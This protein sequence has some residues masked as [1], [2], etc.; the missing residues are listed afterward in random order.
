M[1]NRRVDI[2]PAVLLSAYARGIFPMADQADSPEIYWV[3]PLWRGV[4]PLDGFRVSRSLKKTMRK[5]GY[6]ITAD[7]AFEDV[8]EGCADREETWINKKIRSLYIDLFKLGHAHS[9]EVWHDGALV[10]GLYGVSLGAAFFGESMFNRRPNTSKIALAH[11]V[12]RLNYG[13]Y[14]LLDTQFVTDHLQNFGAELIPRHD[15]LGRLSNAIMRKGDYSAFSAD[16]DADIVL[17]FSTQMS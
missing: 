12:A 7:S 13:G 4:L 11:L 1:S 15:Y 9:L 8:L 10:G 16:C 17:H 5:G 3:N 2:T 14:S 6:T